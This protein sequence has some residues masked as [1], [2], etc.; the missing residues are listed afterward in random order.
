MRDRTSLENQEDKEYESTEVEEEEGERNEY[1]M[2]RQA[3]IANNN[4]RLQTIRDA[5]NILLL[6]R[7]PGMHVSLLCNVLSLG[8]LYLMGVLII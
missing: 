5:A 7:Q 8:S 3:R 1:K 2:F 6:H 4:K